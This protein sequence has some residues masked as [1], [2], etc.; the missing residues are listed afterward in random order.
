V[1][2]RTRALILISLLA[3]SWFATTA[4]ERPPH[5]RD[6]TPT[7]APPPPPP[8]T[9]APAPP[10]P[11]PPP[12]PA[13]APP[14]PQVAPTIYGRITLD[15][16]SGQPGTALT[17][18]GSQLYWNE[19]LTV[20]WD[21]RGHA[22]GRTKTDNN[23]AFTLGV[24]VPPDAPA[25]NHSV[26]LVEEPSIPCDVFAVVPKPSPPVIHVDAAGNTPG[27]RV[28]VTGGNFAP[29]Q[30]IAVMF[31]N[32]EQGA[33][34]ADA[35]GAVT[36]DFDIPDRAPRTYKV[37]LQVIGPTATQPACT[38]LKVAAARAVFHATDSSPLGAALTWLLFLTIGGLAVAGGVYLLRTRMGG[39][40]TAAEVEH[41]VGPPV[42]TSTHREF[43]EARERKS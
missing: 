21:D 7:P 4:A 12:T 24:T 19:N 42:L 29:G 36:A 5:P 38:E 35:Q 16:A 39:V 20:Y 6:P 22:L 25:G 31:D 2:R 32:H 10:P 41:R 33:A 43:W 28:H 14:A 34:T 13:P 3:L 9:P 1:Y 17:V 40:G 27:S 18:T 26:C 37:C 8:P 11:P 30:N 15:P 23:G